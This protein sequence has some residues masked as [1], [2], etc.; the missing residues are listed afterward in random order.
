MKQWKQTNKTKP[1]HDL[2]VCD[3]DDSMVIFEAL[4]TIAALYLR[5]DIEGI[6]QVVMTYKLTDIMTAYVA[7]QLRSF[8]LSGLDLRLLDGRGA[9][10]AITGTL[11][12][13]SPVQQTRRDAGLA[14]LSQ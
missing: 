11:P 1:V 4:R 8:S 2:Q 10:R 3:R 9:R 13:D 14:A 5:A 6:R 7:D 12:L